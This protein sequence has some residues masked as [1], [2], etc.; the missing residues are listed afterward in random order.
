MTKTKTVRSYLLTIEFRNIH[1]PKGSYGF[2]YA[3]G[4]K[5][6]TIGIYDDIIDAYVKGNSLLDSIESK[7]GLYVS[8]NGEVAT[9]RRFNDRCDFVTNLHH[10]NTP[11][12]F[13]AKITTLNYLDVDKTIS[14]ITKAEK[15]YRA[16]ETERMANS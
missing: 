4:C 5:T 12:E 3:Y 13:Y 10:I 2:P 9:K 14:N 7:F 16:Y 1:P 15:D 8:P 11:F 6:V